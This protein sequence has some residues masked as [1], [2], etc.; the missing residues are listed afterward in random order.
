MSINLGVKNYRVNNI[1]NRLSKHEEFKDIDKLILPPNSYRRVNLN[2]YRL[3]KTQYDI[4]VD[5]LLYENT[6]KVSDGIYIMKCNEFYKIGMSSD[7]KKRLNSIQSSNPYPVSLEFNKK[8]SN[9]LSIE[10]QLHEIY[11]HKNIRGEWFKLV[12]ND[13]KDI[14]NYINENSISD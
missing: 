10:K 5:K 3:T 4:I 8:T 1:I 7:I 9:S 6:K 13:I 11:K 2:T 12:D 14:I